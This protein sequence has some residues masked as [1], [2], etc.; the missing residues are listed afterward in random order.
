MCS[1]LVGKEATDEN[2][3]LEFLWTKGTVITCYYSWIIH[4]FSSLYPIQ[5]CVAGHG[6]RQLFTFTFTPRVFLESP[7]NPMRV[8]GLW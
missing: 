7:V 8:F 1:V 4:S 2:N 6:D 3:P 5:S